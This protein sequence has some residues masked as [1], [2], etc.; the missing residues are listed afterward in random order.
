MITPEATLVPPKAMDSMKVSLYIP[1]CCLQCFVSV[2]WFDVLHE[3][4]LNRRAT[5]HTPR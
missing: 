3:P 5:Y 2:L 1:E 4:S